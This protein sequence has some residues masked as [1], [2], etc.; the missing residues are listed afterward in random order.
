MKSGKYFF[1][2]FFIA[3]TVG[4][5]A[6]IN[7]NDIFKTI[8]FLARKDLA[9]RMPGDEGFTKA[10]NF[11]AGEL[12]KLNL[13]PVVGDN[14]FQ[15]FK[16]E[17]NQVLAPEHLSVI[18]GNTRIDY[19]L[20]KDYIFRGFTGS[21]KFIA[22][23]VFCGYGLDQPKPGYND[24]SGVDVKGKIVMV[25]RYNP[26]WNIHD[27]SFTDG[28][29]RE[30]AIVA[31]KHGAVGILFVPFPND[32]DP[33]KPIGSLI[34]G[35]GEQMLNFPEVQLDLP[36]ADELFKGSGKTLKELQTVIDSLK[37]P[38]SVP[39]INKI[40]LE[41]HTKYV[42][43]MEVMNTAGIIEGSDPVLKNEYIILGAHLDHVGSQAGK[44]YFPGANDNASGSAV[45]LQI[46]RELSDLKE[47]PKRSILIV[48][49]ASEEQG[50]NGSKYMSE[51]MLVP[52]E[53]VKA[54][55]N[56]DCVGFGDSIEIGGGKSAPELWNAAKQI[57][58]KNDHLLIDETWNGG[59]ADAEA[60]FKIGIPTLYF[61]SHYSYTHLH[62][63]TDTP[64]TLNKNLLGSI[65]NL[66]YKTVME[67]CN[68]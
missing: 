54:M 14:F 22:P 3:A 49:F 26:K 66:A 6:Q 38:Y 40:D 8:E 46:A 31:A 4:I 25:F 57:D 39:L 17:Y 52:K 53:K 61:E 30:K 68:K 33:Q 48:F 5:N 64:E 11:M 15:K 63:L 32:A 16:V 58:L 24:Y 1:I 21:G 37:K 43:D 23:V 19:Q 44:V 7:K 47:K 28:N 62:M 41:V 9:G 29:P 59:G 10:A 36:V 56:F 18:S 55:F 51:H 65:A 60:F 67:V 50:L 13:R 2:L 42:K 12:K 45:V 34:N 20:G 35:H 27:S